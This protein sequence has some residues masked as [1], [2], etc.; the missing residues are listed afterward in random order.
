MLSNFFRVT[1]RTLYK[2]KIYAGINI[3]GLSLA[4]ACC[5]ILG[6]YLWSELTYDRHHIKHKQ[7]F[8]V[9]N[10]FDINNKLDTFAVT[11]QSLGP[12]LKGDFPEVR[13]FVRFRGA[14]E[15]RLFRHENESFYWNRVYYADENV[16]DIFTHD[17]IYGDP[18]TALEDP[19]SM[20]VC[21]SFAVKFFGD[22]N[23]IGKT[24]KDDS[25]SYKITLVFA[26][27]PDNSHLKYNVLFSYNYL[28]DSDN[29][30]AR[31][32][33]L[34]LVSEY[35]YLL[36]PENFDVQSFKDISDTFYDRHMADTAKTLNATWRCWIQPLADIHFHSD[37]G[38]DEPTG[39]KLYVYGFT[40]VAIFILLVACINYM[41]LA[42]ARAAKR[43]KEVGMRKILGSGRT[44]LVVQFL[45]EAI[46][47][48]IIALVF[49][50]VIVKL[51]FNLTAINDLLDK[52]LTL[53][54]INEPFL[55]LSMLAFSLIVGLMSGIYPAF[56][57][58]S[59]LPLSA[60]A[61]GIKA[62]KGKIRLREILVLL[63]FII[64]VSVI[65]CAIIMTLQIHYVANKPLGFNKEN[66]LVI[67]LR[68]A[69]LIEKMPT[70]RTELFKN[71]SILGI[72]TS[73]QMIGQTTPI[74]VANIDNNDG[75]LEE[76]SL[77]H[78]M[79]GD[80][81]LKVMGM[82]LLEGRDFTKK[83]LTDVG[84]SFV[85]NETMVK[86]MG[87]DEPLGKRI[88]LGGGGRV[89]GVVKDFHFASLH[90]QVEPFAMHRNFDTSNIPEQQR[91]QVQRFLI[92]HISGEEIFKTLGFLEENFSGFD[93]RHPF[94]YEFL[95][96][97]LNKLYLSEQR[98]MK[99]IGIFAGVCILIS[100]L[101][102]FG[103][104]A[105][106]TEQRSK[107]IAIRKV[108]GASTIQII[109]MLA[110][111]ILL[112][113]LGGAVIASLIAYYTMDE[114][115]TGFAYRTDIEPWVFPMSAVLAALVAFITIALQSFKTAQSNPVDAL[116]Y[117]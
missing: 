5:I 52:P 83:L 75:V 84:S 9:V 90:S 79:V 14:G 38:Y 15:D 59:I 102:L 76:T 50:I 41:N 85:V 95:D 97:A 106:T 49:G 96:D 36:M 110:R 69:D 16:F 91:P 101:G 45:G 37:V 104:S 46:F 116:R 2:E 44:R 88:Q 57:L 19:S 70:I 53:D 30:T 62:G 89:I 105:F 34:F 18:K 1:L 115:L 61:A 26:D 24:I 17:I 42:T 25:N 67:T 74:N 87:W 94:K 111:N 47:F 23:P 54:L 33:R 114:W 40:A 22:Q 100:C 55:L 92:L 108:L 4:I 3:F 10:E 20:A 12:L 107:E 7:I 6:L 86:K 39:N 72:T 51:A 27:L 109:T 98:L 82:E 13:D 28:P 43:A 31:R 29:A 68:G 32:Q 35:T 113:V 58:S 66:R 8:R 73:S 11:S 71:S 81:Y 117:E 56:Y 103:L 78:M 64:T 63:Q 93:P 80:E 112:L 48:S 99:L 21:K 77:K 60:L 65:A